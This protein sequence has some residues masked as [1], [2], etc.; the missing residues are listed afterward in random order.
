MSL[1]LPEELKQRVAEAARL[2]G[3]SED[4]YMREAIERVVGEEVLTTRPR[5]HWGQFESGDPT[6]S[7]RVD[8]ILAEGFGER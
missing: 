5:P 3:V 7:S 2:H 1:Y 8:E 4:D 6:L